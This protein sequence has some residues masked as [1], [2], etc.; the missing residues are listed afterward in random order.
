M[1]NPKFYRELFGVSI[2]PHVLGAGKLAKLRKTM[3]LN[4]KTLPLRLEFKNL[5]P[6]CLADSFLSLVE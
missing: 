3:R 5:F 2:L 4:L 6:I 1:V